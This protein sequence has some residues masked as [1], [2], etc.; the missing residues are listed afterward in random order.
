MSN[1]YIT[2]LVNI[3]DEIDSLQRKAMSV[4]TA[5]LT[6]LTVESG[7]DNTFYSVCREGLDIQFQETKQYLA[8][9]KN[10]VLSA[11]ASITS[12]V[13]DSNSGHFAAKSSILQSIR[14]LGAQISISRPHLALMK[15]RFEQNRFYSV[16]GVGFETEVC[17]AEVN[18]MLDNLGGLKPMVIKTEKKEPENS[19]PISTEPKP[20]S[21]GNYRPP[22]TT[23]DTPSPKFEQSS[24]DIEMDSSE[25]D[26]ID[27]NLVDIIQQPRDNIDAN[28]SL[29]ISAHERLMML[30]RSSDSILLKLSDFDLMSLKKELD[31]KFVD[32]EKKLISFNMEKSKQLVD[33]LNVVKSIGMNERTEYRELKDLISKFGNV[34]DSISITNVSIADTLK[35]ILRKGAKTSSDQTASVEL[36]N[37]VARLSAQFLDQKKQLQQMVK[38]VKNDIEN[39]ITDKINVTEIDGKIAQLIEETQKFT[40]EFNILEQYN[41]VITALDGS[42]YTPKVLNISKV[43]ALEWRQS[44]RNNDGMPIE[45]RRGIMNIY[46]RFNVLYNNTDEGRQYI[47]ENFEY[48]SQQMKI[49][50]GVKK[51]ITDVYLNTSTIFEFVINPQKRT[52]LLNMFRA[53]YEKIHKNAEQVAS[54]LQETGTG[55]N[56]NDFNLA[57]EVNVLDNTAENVTSTVVGLKS[58]ETTLGATTDASSGSKM[59][60]QSIASKRTAEDSPNTTA[61]VRKGAEGNDTTGDVNIAPNA[62]TKVGK[63]VTKDTT[64]PKVTVRRLMK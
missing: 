29:L 60:A 12:F 26:Y 59:E 21:S 48:I 56:G 32:F 15:E 58:G 62:L 45:A 33:V 19:S 20:E 24:D 51:Y 28:T 6:R 42:D 37:E 16:S 47:L 2:E 18:A 25:D 9:T 38:E 1:E 43:Y 52:E 8:T 63:G 10:L 5:N 4:F 13:G 23:V 30:E 14:G 35:E 11:I 40:R 39:F 34:V 31:N 57:V 36:V 54:N 44:L 55:E 41:V 53:E 49:E 17:L 61:K 3:R 27:D 7:V 50:E 64:R 22:T 46:D